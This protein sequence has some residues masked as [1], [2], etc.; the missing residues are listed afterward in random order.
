MKKT[1][2]FLSLL[3]LS[4]GLYAGS[5][6]PNLFVESLTIHKTVE[7]GG[8]EMYFSV[9]EYPSTGKGK[10]INIPPSPLSWTS[11]Q[12]RDLKNLKLWGGNLAEGESTEVIVELI[13]HDLPPW[14]V[15]DLI[16][17]FKIKLM[18]QDGKLVTEWSQSNL[19]KITPEKI[20]QGESILYHMTG[21]GAHYDVNI[22]LEK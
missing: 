22:V 18:N 1:G 14:N 17:V 9:T 15:D 3:I 13:E 10:T 8:D 7:K 20:K 19:Q 2:L 21:E 12:V 16:G 4:T 5:L 11:D 6:T